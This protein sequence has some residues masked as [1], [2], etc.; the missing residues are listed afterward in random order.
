MRRTNQITWPIVISVAILLIIVALCVRQW[1]HTTLK[2]EFEQ[3]PSRFDIV[4]Q[5][6]CTLP[7]NKVLA[8]RYNDLNTT[9]DN[10]PTDVFQALSSIFQGANCDGVF[11]GT[12]RT[13]SKKYCK[14]IEYGKEVHTGLIYI[15][16]CSN[17]DEA[18][19]AFFGELI[20]ELS[21]L[22]DGW[23]YFEVVSAEGEKAIPG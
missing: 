22:S 13:S 7:E 3:D 10:F 23:F 19:S 15:L 9:E 20:R 6:L 1:S 8:I 17:K 11:T 5:Y 14:F 2:T 21:P 16:N 18:S 4:S 12:T